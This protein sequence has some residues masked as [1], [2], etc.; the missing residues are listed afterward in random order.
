MFMERSQYAHGV[1]RLAAYGVG[2]CSE[3]KAAAVGIC[4]SEL[5][6]GAMEDSGLIFL[7]QPVDSWVHMDGVIVEYMAMGWPTGKWRA[8]EAV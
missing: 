2:T 1:S 3:P 5:D 8:F 4:V 6:H 7:F